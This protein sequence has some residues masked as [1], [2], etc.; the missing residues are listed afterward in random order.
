MNDLIDRQMLKADLLCGDDTEHDYCFP[1]KKILERIDNQPA[2]E[3]HDKR[4]EMHSCDCVSKTSVC[5]ILADIYPTD[6]EKVVA[7]KEVDKAYEAIQQLPSAQPE[8]I[9]CKDCKHRPIR[10]NGYIMPPEDDD[11]ICPCLCEDF[12]YSWRPRDD[13]FCA[14]GERKND[15]C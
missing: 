9:L 2:V 14:R 12:F 6:G 15:E 8:I 3:T 11:M 4:T 13:F 1:C 10:K 7:V 5:E